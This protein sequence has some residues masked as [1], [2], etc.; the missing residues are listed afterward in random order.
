[1]AMEK[2]YICAMEKEAEGIIKKFK[3]QKVNENTYKNE[4]YSLYSY[5]TKSN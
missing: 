4:Q 5:I 2:L 1:M 3:M